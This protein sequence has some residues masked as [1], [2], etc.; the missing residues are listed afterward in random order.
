MDINQFI[1]NKAARV[2][3][4]TYEVC[5]SQNGYLWRFVVHAGH[6]N[7]QTAANPPEND[8]VSG[9]IPSLVLRLLNG[10]E[11]KGHT[12][13]MDNFYN[14]PAL[15][16]EMKSRGFNC[17]GTIRL[18]RQCVPV[19]LA[20]LTKRDMTAGELCGATSGDV[21]IIV[22]RDKNLVNLISTYHGLQTV[23]CGNKIK[24]SVVAD[25]N[26]CMGGVDRKDQILSMYPIERK[27]TR[28]WYKKFFRRLLNV[29]VLNAYIL[30]KASQPDYSHRKFR[31]VLVT[32][33]LARHTV[34][35]P[36]RPIAMVNHDPAQYA[37]VQD[38]RQRAE[39]IRRVCALCKKKTHTYCTGCNVT[40]CTYT[41]FGPYH[42]PS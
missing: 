18:Q 26:V 29:S 14:S 40:L 31:K 13:W 42:R 38:S 7:D 41:C 32:Q 33:I 39:R 1:P 24:P 17:V 36:P 25:Y 28:V 9:A 27:R 3:I 16:R 11:Y 23:R 6:D 30:F 35:K 5:D 22:W 15:A 19:E 34:I 2:G 21:D 12:V 37:V 10:L 4:K 8:A 20:T